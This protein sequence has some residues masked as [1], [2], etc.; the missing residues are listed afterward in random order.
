MILGST[1]PFQ[2]A[3]RKYRSTEPAL[4]RIFNDS[5]R[6]LI[7]CALNWSAAFDSVDHHILLRRLWEDFEIA[8]TPLAWFE[9]CLTK[10]RQMVR[11]AGAVSKTCQIIYE[12]PQGS[13]LGPKVRST[14]PQP[15]CHLLSFGKRQ[16]GKNRQRQTRYSLKTN[17]LV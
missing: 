1:S 15:M 17:L 2:S 10:R 16:W 8:D 9:W 14:L 4:L 11:A 13:V 3:Y 7:L 5:L 12:F 6:Q